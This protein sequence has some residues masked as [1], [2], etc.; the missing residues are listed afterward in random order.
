MKI[1]CI[2]RVSRIAKKKAYMGYVVFELCSLRKT[3]LASLLCKMYIKKFSQGFFLNQTYYKK[4]YLN[5]L[6]ALNS[7][8]ML[9]LSKNL[10]KFL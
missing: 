9:R 7:I 6:Y 4:K 3:Q 10:T 1:G 8:L 2:A 5:P